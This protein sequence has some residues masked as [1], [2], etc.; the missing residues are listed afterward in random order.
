MK[1]IICA[2]SIVF[3][4]S[5]C[6]DNA[7]SVGAGSGSESKSES[8][9]L[10]SKK[11]SIEAKEESA[12]SIKLP[13][14]AVI[15]SAFSTRVPGKTQVI[16]EDMRGG[17][18]PEFKSIYSDA[19]ELVQLKSKSQDEYKKF[20]DSLPTSM[21]A[22]FSNQ[23]KQILA[24][25]MIRMKL[26]RRINGCTNVA[27]GW[28]LNPMQ[29]EKE[30]QI[31]MRNFANM[32][33]FTNLIFTEIAG[34]IGSKAIK[35][36]D[37]AEENVLK[38]W[39]EIPVQT[40]AAVWK[41]VVKNNEESGFGADLTGVK[42]IKFMSK[43]AVYWNQ[44]AGFRVEKN[45]VVWFGDGAVSGKVVDFNLRSSLST[46]AEKSKTQNSSEGVQSGSKTG[47]EIGVK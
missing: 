2:L 39:D 11:K 1:S 46:K 28:D 43:D 17:S 32:C 3:L 38:V 37:E 20:L 6:S 19:A 36:P 13:A 21:Q 18:D 14:I 24:D 7:A 5:A 25:N 9:S 31:Y 34:K 45:G 29:H 41:Q 44:G 22:K 15:S 33:D 30:A 26:E 16:A 27:N 35:D 8:E 23:D 47:A 42:G 40:I 4:L 10:I 12:V